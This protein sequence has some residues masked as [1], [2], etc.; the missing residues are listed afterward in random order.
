MMTYFFEKTTIQR[1]VQ[2]RKITGV[3]FNPMFIRMVIHGWGLKN[4]NREDFLTPIQ[5]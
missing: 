3:Q 1:G 5:R 2:L 4:S